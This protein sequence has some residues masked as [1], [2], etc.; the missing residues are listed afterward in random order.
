MKRKSF[1]IATLALGVLAVVGCASVIHPRNHRA[2]SLYQYLYSNEES[3]VDKPT[4][5]TLSLPLR[6][7]VAFVPPDS[8][9]KSTECFDLPEE[10][11]I[12]LMNQI[13]A[14]FKTYPFVK[15]IDIIP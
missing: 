1:I 3:H 13:S 4:I 2:T 15:S 7:G 6:V 9:K 8:E 5:P 14:Q 11:K 10:T 12:K